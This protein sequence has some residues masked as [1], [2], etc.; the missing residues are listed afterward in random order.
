M[1][2]DWF[3]KLSNDNA[4]L[5]AELARLRE[6][7]GEA[8]QMAGQVG[9]AE[10]IL[11]NLSDAANGRPL[12]HETFLP[13]T[14]DDFSELARK[15]ELQYKAEELLNRWLYLAK[16]GLLSCGFSPKTL[17]RETQAFLTDAGW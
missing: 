11:D 8:Y 1:G 14:D 12:R 9:A 7:C 16:K 17:D 6:V 2:I 15:D 5:R 10:R 13:V 4:E 3:L